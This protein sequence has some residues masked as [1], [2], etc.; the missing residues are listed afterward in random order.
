MRLAAESVRMM[1]LPRR[2]EAV[3]RR[4]LLV[5]QAVLVLACGVD[6]R[7]VSVGAA[8]SG[9]TEL[10]RPDGSSNGG[11]PS[12]CAGGSTCDAGSCDGC[13]IDGVCVPD[14]TE[15]GE[16]S[17]L[18]CDTARSLSSYSVD[19]GK[20]CGAAATECS[21]EDTCD[22]Q[23]RCAPNHLPATTRCGTQPQSC[24]NPDLCDGSGACQSGVAQRVELCDAVDNDCDGDNNEGF[25]VN[26]D[27]ENCGRCGHSCL[28]GDCNAGACQL[29]IVAD[30]GAPQVQ[31]RAVGD[32]VY[33]SDAG[34]FNRSI[35]RVRRDG[36]GLEANVGLALGGLRSFDEDGAF[37]Y[38]WRNFSAEIFLTRCDP[39]LSGADCANGLEAVQVPLTLDRTTDGSA[40]AID[41]TGHR[42][43]WYNL[44]DNTTYVSSTSAFARSALVG[45]FQ[46]GTF[47]Y[48]SDALWGVDASDATRVSRVPA[49][50]DFPSTVAV[51]ANATGFVANATR[52]YWISG[53]HVS[54]VNMPFGNGAAAPNA[55]S[56]P[57]SPSALAVDGTDLYWVEST[58]GGDIV[59][60]CPVDGC[61]ASGPS[62]LTSPIVDA[63]G[64]A[65]DDR[66]V[67][68]AA[69]TETRIGGQ[70]I[71]G[72][73]LLVAK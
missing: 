34:S 37:Y 47:I 10:D 23:G 33:S 38:I 8:G 54:F 63:L 41:R 7:Q 52:L 17:C 12:E 69:G 61:P 48:A 31:V 66:A 18:V 64:L 16:N 39:A 3:S 20:A 6:D 11:A 55:F 62:T 21:G 19:V 25:D 22:A 32:Y 59:R 30:L 67:Y 51:E 53:D 58:T 36:S 27:S 35:H 65:V 71:A 46:Q 72:G 28:G 68:V 1:K 15:D 56:G 49:T 60:R 43:F 40:V 14:G 29:R 42:V 4:W 2:L 73:V 13:L 70:E 57:A 24:V 5:T 50:G 9:Q 44:A 45:N 26:E